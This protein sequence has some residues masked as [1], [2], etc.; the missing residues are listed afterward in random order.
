MIISVERTKLCETVGNLSRVVSSK[1]TVPVLEGILIC[2]ENGQI[3]LSAYNLE[4]G[5]TKKI[6]ATI[7]EAGQIVISAKVFNSI[8]HSLKGDF[9]RIKTDDRLMCHIESD[10]AV[11]DIMGMAAV[12]FPEIP[13][14]ADGKRISITAG[15]LK[16]MVRETIFAVAPTEGTRPIL[17]GLDFEIE[18][19]SLKI[20]AIDG[21]RL[22]IRKE[23]V[24]LNENMQFVV[25]GR[26]VAEIVKIISD[27]DADINMTI[28]RRHICF[29]V[30][31]YTFIAPLLDGDF[32]DYKRT[33]PAAFSQTMVVDTRDL[34]EVIE[35]ISLIIND[36]FT[37]PVRCIIGEEETVFSCATSVGR[38]T[39]KAAIK[40]EGAP[41]EIGLNSKYLLEALRACDYEKVKISF[42]GGS[43]AVVITPEVDDT[44]TYMIM[45]MRLK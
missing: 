26:A 29:L 35:R 3:S 8:L 27:E 24:N 42:N 43:A 25:S 44:C 13:T 22:A 12:D 7:E 19:G 21:Y 30:E 40:L 18:E 23:K 31:G 37:T 16:E 2:T 28:G 45:P 5:L 6:D 11:F 20:V 33:I 15:I 9:V 39:E 10:T 14:I 38:A 17:T 4:N 32:I 36:N 34:I 1:T 41:F